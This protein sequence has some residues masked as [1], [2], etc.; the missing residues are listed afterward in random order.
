MRGLACFLA[1]AAGPLSGSA[2]AEFAYS[3]YLI[4]V[5]ES[6]GLVLHGQSDR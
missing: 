2:S 4:D 1:L 6:D 3:S 5:A